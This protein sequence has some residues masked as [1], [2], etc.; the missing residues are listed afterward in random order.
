MHLKSFTHFILRMI[1]A[2]TMFSMVKWGKH[3]PRKR[4]WFNIHHSS[5]TKSFPQTYFCSLLNRQRTSGINSWFSWTA[6]KHVTNRY[7]VI[8]QNFGISAW[9]SSKRKKSL[10]EENWEDRTQDIIVKN[11]SSVGYWMQYMK[12]KMEWPNIHED[13][14]D[15]NHHTCISTV[16]SHLKDD[17]KKLQ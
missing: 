9:I 7:N 16:I 13:E 6:Y 14:K 5:F 4:T 12:K 17:G 10:K 3:V 11:T 1:I 8:L 2:T 15:Q